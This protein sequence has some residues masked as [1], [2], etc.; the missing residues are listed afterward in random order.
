ME[1]PTDNALNPRNLKRTLLIRDLSE[2]PCGS[3]LLTNVRSRLW[4]PELLGKVFRLFAKTFVDFCSLQDE[5]YAAD[6]KCY[7]WYLDYATLRDHIAPY[8]QHDGDFEILIP[9]CGNSSIES[10]IVFI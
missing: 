2:G 3:T 1:D 7:D 4:E 5:R 9:G 6:E 8:L 10:C